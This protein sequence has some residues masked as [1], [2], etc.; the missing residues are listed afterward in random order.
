[1]S[2]RHRLE[3]GALA[4]LATALLAGFACCL[5]LTTTSGDPAPWLVAALWGTG[6]SALLCAFAACRVDADPG[7][8]P[9]YLASIARGLRQEWQREKIAP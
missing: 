8:D 3:R 4:S 2:T 9:E 1:M 7:E 6:L 5:L